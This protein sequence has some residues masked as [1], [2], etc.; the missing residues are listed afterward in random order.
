MVRVAWAGLLLVMVQLGGCAGKTLEEGD[1]AAAAGGK[2][3]KPPPGTSPVTQCK[4][5][6]STWCNK[7][8]GCYVKVGRLPESQRKANTDSCIKLFVEHAPC[9]EVTSVGSEYNTCIAQI[10][11]MACSQ[12]NVP[13]EQFGT[14]GEPISCESSLAFD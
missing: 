12:W 1:D 6:A 4:S 10:N 14:I 9:A 11:A 8:F 2:T 5:L 7:A 3:S 13:Q